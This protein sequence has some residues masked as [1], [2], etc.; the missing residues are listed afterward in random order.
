MSA[1][2]STYTTLITIRHTLTTNAQWWFG[3]SNIQFK[4]EASLYYHKIVKFIRFQC[5]WCIQAVAYDK[6]N[7]DGYNHF[8]SCCVLFGGISVLLVVLFDGG[9]PYYDNVNFW[10]NID[11]FEMLFILRIYLNSILNHSS[12]TWKI[13]QIFCK[14]PQKYAHK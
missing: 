14:R 10:I 9:K 12:T 7:F 6:Q 2:Y 4:L 3:T 11:I 1:L 5:I 8:T 13:L